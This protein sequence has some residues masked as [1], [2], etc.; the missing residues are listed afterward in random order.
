MF[1]IITVIKNIN[2]D[3][4]II[5]PPEGIDILK[6]IGKITPK[7]QLNSEKNIL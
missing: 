5:A 6:W 3:I 4:K 1:F 7:I 2:E